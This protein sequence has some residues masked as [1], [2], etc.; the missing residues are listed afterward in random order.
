MENFIKN[1]SNAYVLLKKGKPEESIKG[2]S[3]NERRAIIREGVDL[4]VK[5]FSYH[6]EHEHKF[7]LALAMID[8][9]PQLKKKNSENSGI[10]NA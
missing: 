10:V 4:L 3:D 9:F 8:L 2:L 7:A 1:S 6:P 5:K